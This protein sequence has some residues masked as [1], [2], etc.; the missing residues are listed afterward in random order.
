MDFEE[1]WQEASPQRPPP[2]LSSFVDPQ[3]EI[4]A[5]AFDCTKRLTNSSPQP[6]NGF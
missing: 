6:L 1:T 5:M 2:S 3:S 4:A